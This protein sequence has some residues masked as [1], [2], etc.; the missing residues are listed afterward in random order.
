MEDSLFCSIRLNSL[1][2]VPNSEPLEWFLNDFPF[3]RITNY[4][5]KEQEKIDKTRTNGQ[6]A[7]ARMPP[8]APAADGEFPRATARRPPHVGGPVRRLRSEGE[9]LRARGACVHRPAERAAGGRASGG[10]VARGET[11]VTTRSAGRSRKPTSRRQRCSGTSGSRSSPSARTLLSTRCSKSSS[12]TRTRSA[13]AGRA[14]AGL[15]RRDVR[16]DRRGL[17]RQRLPVHHQDRRGGPAH[18]GHLL[19]GGRERARGDPGQDALQTAARLLEVVPETLE[20]VALVRKLLT[21][22]V[23]VRRDDPAADRR[24]HDAEDPPCCADGD[25]AAADVVRSRRLR[26]RLNA[27]P[28]RTV[29]NE[30]FSRC[31]LA[32]IH[33]KYIKASCKPCSQH[34]Y[35]SHKP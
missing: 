22:I 35:S 30:Q 3:V 25:G 28:T 7:A 20:H 14:A 12:T 9:P 19:H 13:T 21:A 8:A 33:F 27:V 17:R 10:P 31:F 2:N 6:S 34:P 1:S 4:L 5:L 23:D 32:T 15:T 24:R 16:A 26:P 18:G 11:R 29:R